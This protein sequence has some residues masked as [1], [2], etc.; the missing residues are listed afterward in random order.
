MAVIGK[1]WIEILEEKATTSD[2]DSV[3]YEIRAAIRQEK[4]FMPLLIDGAQMPRL[5][6]LVKDIRK[7]YFQNGLAIESNSTVTGIQAKLRDPISKIV[8]G[9]KL[10]SGWH[11]AYVIAAVIGYYFCAINPHIFGVW[12]FG[13]EPWLN[14][15]LIWSG[16]FIWPIFFLPFVLLALYRPFSTLVEC[17]VNAIHWRESVVYST[18]FIAATVLSFL[19]VLIEVSPP[20]VPWTVHAYGPPP[21]C[22]SEHIVSQSRADSSYQDKVRNV[23]SYDSA[24]TL[25]MQYQDK[26]WL[27][28]KCWPNAFF[29]LTIPTPTTVLNDTYRAERPRIAT[30]FNALLDSADTP[31]SKLFP[32]YVVSFTI[33]IWLTALG[34]VMS[35]F[36]VTV[37]IRRPHD[38]RVRSIPSEDAYLCLTYAFVALMVWLPFRV[39][40]IHYKEL[41]SCITYPCSEAIGPYVKDFVFAI[42]LL[43]A[44]IYLTAGLL[45]KYKRVALSILGAAAIAIFLSGTVGVFVFPDVAASL[46]E[47][48]Q[49]FVGIAILV[50][51][52]LLGLW[53]QFDPA[54]VHFNDFRRDE[55]ELDASLLATAADVD[56]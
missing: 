35:I 46:A 16:L 23:T 50:M 31:Y 51:L 4:E 43:I 20:Q 44:F 34:I 26:F 47:N 49:T 56:T 14:L 6:E 24:R 55:I 36:Y 12:E 9:R 13:R 25:E 52:I 27:R 10:A 11:R 37:G 22:S 15:T 48:W 17:A 1:K 41:Y 30:A 8:R 33:L 19:A 28:N 53:Y 38:G 5:R 39:N 7:L 18:P 40:T 3:A 2:R 42:A 32:S 45:I 29:Y 21:Q 54:I